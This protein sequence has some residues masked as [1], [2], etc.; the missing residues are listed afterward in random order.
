MFSVIKETK[1]DSSHLRGQRLFVLCTQPKAVYCKGVVDI[2]Q[3]S[4]VRGVYLDTTDETFYSQF[5][6][7]SVSISWQNEV[8]RVPMGYDAGRKRVCARARACLE[9]TLRTGRG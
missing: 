1:I 6:T 4:T 3:F 8:L 9:V 5:A 7:G 2:D